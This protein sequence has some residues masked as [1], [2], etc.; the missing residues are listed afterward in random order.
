MQAGLGVLVPSL[1]RDSIRRAS[2]IRVVLVGIIIFVG[3]EQ[4]EHSLLTFS[5]H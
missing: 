3:E 4:T 1:K 2:L 5:G